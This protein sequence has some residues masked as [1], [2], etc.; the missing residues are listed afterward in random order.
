[1]FFFFYLFSLQLTEELLQ[2]WIQMTKGRCLNE[3]W[4]EFAAFSEVWSC[5]VDAD[6]EAN[7]QIK[8]WFKIKIFEVVFG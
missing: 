5:G 6:T 7:I 8:V 2:T 4:G 3:C 1:M